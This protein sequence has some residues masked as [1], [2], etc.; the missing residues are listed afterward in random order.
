M[1]KNKMLAQEN[2]M[3]SPWMRKALLVTVLA[4]AVLAAGCGSNPE[5]K[6]RD[7]QGAVT[8]ELKGGMATLDYGRIRIDGTYTVDGN[9]ITMRPTVGN[10]SQT[11]VFTLNKDSS[12]DGPPGSDITGLQKTK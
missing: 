5:G 7:A 12:I 2:V 11:M 8:L 4:A 6:Y 3:K 10:T 9:K 1:Q